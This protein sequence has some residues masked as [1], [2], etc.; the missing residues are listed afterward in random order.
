MEANL[1]LGIG[2]IVGGASKSVARVGVKRGEDIVAAGKVAGRFF[3]RGAKNVPAPR[4]V[5]PRLV[6]PP[7][8]APLAGRTAMLSPAARTTLIV[9]G[10]VGTLGATAPLWSPGLRQGIS[11]PLTGAGEGAAEAGAGLG[12]GFAGLLSGFGAGTGAGIA[13]TLGGVGQ[14]IRSIMGP[15]LLVGGGFLVFKAVKK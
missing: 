3:S 13:N 10:T 5:P 8:S 7:P 14:G 11:D 1:T 9:G 12:A 6:N 15:L 2:A 4:H